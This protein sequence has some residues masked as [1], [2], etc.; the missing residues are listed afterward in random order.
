MSQPGGDLHGI[1]GAGNPVPEVTGGDGGDAFSDEPLNHCL[2][3][4]ISPSDAVP[5]E[6][7][8]GVSPE[9]FHASVVDRRV[10]RVPQEVQ[11]PLLGI[12][13]YLLV[14]VKMEVI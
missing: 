7:P 4:E 12:C 2:I 9:P 14:M 10:R 3:L 6:L 13:N 1:D 8:F 5:G 11:L